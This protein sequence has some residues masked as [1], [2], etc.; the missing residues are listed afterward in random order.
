MTNSNTRANALAERLLLGANTLATFAEGLSDAQWN[1]PV[2]GDGRTI[3]VVVHHVANVYPLEI[4]LAQVLASGNPITE[5]T[6]EV[7]NQMNADH[8][9]EFAGVNKQEAIALL[10]QNSKI[11]AESIRAFTDAELDQSAKVSLNANAPLTAQFFI[12]DH[13]LRHSF[14]HFEKIKNTIKK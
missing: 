3:G 10:R 9:K 12:E 4:E 8:A 14:H 7:V 2:L 1:Q 6:M 5:A 11:A 13:A